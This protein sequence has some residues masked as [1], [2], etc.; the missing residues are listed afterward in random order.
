MT[1]RP[2]PRKWRGTE[3]STALPWPALQ[4]HRITRHSLTYCSPHQRRAKE[5]IFLVTITC[6]CNLLRPPSVLAMHS[7]C[8]TAAYAPPPPHVTR[9]LKPS[10]S[11]RAVRWASERAVSTYSL[12]GSRSTQQR[13]Q[14]KGEDRYHHDVHSN[15]LSTD[16]LCHLA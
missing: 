5:D 9:C 8:V 2:T 6:H 16:C 13:S 12:S 14:S 3:T 10:R 7:H 1:D 11:I 15:P 4:P